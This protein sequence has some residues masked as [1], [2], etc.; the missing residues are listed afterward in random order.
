M[1]NSLVIVIGAYGSGKSEY[2]VNM[3][4]KWREGG[5][6][7]ILAD[8][9]VVNPY[10][11]S[12]TVSEEFAREGIEVIAPEGSYKHADLPM[13][14]PRILG[15]I[16]NLN[17][18][19]ILDVGGDPAGCNTLARFVTA[20]TA[21]GYEMH[22][23]VN[24]RR[25]FTRNEKEITSM[26]ESLEKASHLRISHLICNT[27]LMEYTDADVIKQGIITIDKVAQTRELIF[28]KFLT[29]DRYA[30]KIPDIILHK[31]K[32]IL[33]YYLR[34]PWESPVFRGI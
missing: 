26:L 19:V 2:S 25:P 17:R 30:D 5:Q 9:D 1:K 7:I 11:R 4:R 14:S 27:N 23:V 16:Q 29:L 8:L 24:T 10:F 34:K 33:K 13:I 31:K 22:F 15:A 18:T 32:E 20:I 12:R 6:E 21:R 3:A 28:E